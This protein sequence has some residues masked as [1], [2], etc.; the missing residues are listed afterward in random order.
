M[1]Q[2]IKDRILAHEKSYK[3]LCLWLESIYANE[4]KMLFGKSLFS[5]REW[6]NRDEPELIDGAIVILEIKIGFQSEEMDYILQ[7]LGARRYDVTSYPL[8]RLHIRFWVPL[9][10]SCKTLMTASGKW[11]P[12]W[13]RYER[14]NI[15]TDDNEQ[16]G[17]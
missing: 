6:L 9:S 8:N 10:N 1:K 3:D 7:L 13:R 17:K 16:E 5:Y 11:T 14:K 2:E 4:I 15:K 12:Y